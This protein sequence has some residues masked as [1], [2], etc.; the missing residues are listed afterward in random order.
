MEKKEIL[1]KVI[2]VIADSTGIEKEEILPG[3][4]LFTELGINSIDMLDVLFSLEMEYD[5][6]LN[7]S[8]IEQE[9]RGEMGGVAFEVENIITKEGL[10]VLKRRMPEIPPDKFVDGMTINNIISLIT[11]E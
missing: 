10:E 8:D 2:E 3:S 9:S 7:V 4:T 5:I 11:V 1:E 6:S